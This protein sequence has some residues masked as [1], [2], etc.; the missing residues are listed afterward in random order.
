MSG[1]RLWRVPL[2]APVRRRKVDMHLVREI[3]TYGD[4]RVAN[5]MYAE[6]WRWKNPLKLQEECMSEYVKPKGYEI[7]IDGKYDSLFRDISSA[8]TRFL[9]LKEIGR[10]HV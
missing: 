10:A 1:A 2:E 8:K 9:Q 7:T 4:V 6:G 3:K 5:A